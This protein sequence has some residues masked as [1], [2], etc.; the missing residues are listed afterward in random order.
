[1]ATVF[2][3]AMFIN[4]I[5]ATVVNVALPTIARDLGVPVEHTATVNIGFLVAVAVAI[6]VVGW[7]GDRFGPR[8]V[9]IVA[10]SAFTA[11]SAACGLAGTV[12]QLVVFRI[13]Q[14]LG[15]GLMTPSGMAM[16]YRTFPPQERVRVSKMT[17]VPIAIAPTIGPVL[18]GLL[19]EHASWRWIFGLNVPVG[20]A[21]LA[22]TFAFVSPLPRSVNHRLDI[23][24][25]LLAGVGFAGLMFAVSEG[26]SHGW[27]SPLI[28]GAGLTGVVLL[29]V[30]VP[31]QL[32]LVHPMLNLR[33][34]ALKLFRTANV[35]TICSSAGFLGGLFVYP[36]MLQNALGYSAF[37]AGLLTFPEALGVMVGTQLVG[38]FYARVGPRRL[39]AAGQFTVGCALLV[40]AL[41]MT[42]QTPVVVP[43][44]LMA[45]MGLAQAHT[46]MPLQA[47]A[48]DTVPRADIGA[49]TGLYNA[50]RQAGSAVGV[51]IAATVISLIGVGSTPQAALEP[52]RWAMI[53]CACF[54]LIASLFALWQVNDAD[55]APS[56]GLAPK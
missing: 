15:G 45:V 34:F 1:M 6:P 20:I 5:D 27:G 7:L 39:V 38:R 46:F 26:P 10:L 23:A 24:G 52:F 17:N 19:V 21:A 40:M 13:L 11:A 29:S 33:L 30:L 16:L 8:G 48:F 36:L 51:A 49:A 3:A 22:F 14:G 4:I 37:D 9:F 44:V 50:T 28:L 32:S 53:A 12:G 55:A 31:V 35:I 43:I 47:A 2:V 54:P 56:R 41:V 42:A 25:F 18:G